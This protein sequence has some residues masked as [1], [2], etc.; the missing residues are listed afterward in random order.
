MNHRLSGVNY[1]DPRPYEIAHRKVAR[2]A[3][4]E[5]MVL[6][7]NEDLFPLSKGTR[8]ALY[9]VGS[10]FPIKGGSGSGDVN[11]RETVN[12]RDGLKNA[13]YAIVNE[14][15]LESYK[16]AYEG[17][18]IAWR[19]EIFT[20]CDEAEK[21]TG[22]PN[23]FYVYAGT[24]FIA[25]VGEDPVKENADVAIFVLS[26]TA[27]EGADRFD[28]EG[29][30]QA[31]KEER[32]FI[33][34]LGKL[35]PA[36]AVILNI[37]SVM[38]LN[39]LDSVENLK[40][41]LLMGQPGMEAGNAVADII[42]G[43]V[44]PGGK[45]TDTWALEYTDYPNSATFSHNNGNVLKEYYEE[46]LYVGY[47]YFD[48]F[49]VPVRYPYGYGLSYTDFAIET[50][51]TTGKC[52]KDATSE[53]SGTAWTDATSGSSGT[54]GTDATSGAAGTTGIR[55]EGA[56]TGEPKVIL[57]VDVKNTGAKYAGTEVVQLYA[58]CPQEK[59]AKE[60]RRMI[61]FAKT[62]TLAPGESQKLEISFP[63]YALASY[64]ESLPGWIL[65]KGTY[66]I[67]AGNSI[68]TSVLAASVEVKEDAV[69][70][71][72]RHICPLKEELHELQ[73][74]ADKLRAK[75]E[76]WLPKTAE[77]PKVTVN[78]GDIITRT[79]VYT[80]AYED[81]P[82]EVRKFVDTLSEEQM[83]LL[84]TGDVAAG[85]GS[86][87]GNAGSRV[88]GSAA[89]TSSC[90][91]EQGLGDFVLADGPAGLRLNKE[92]HVKDG[93]PI[94][95]PFS[96]SIEN[97]FLYRGPELTEGEVMYQFCTAIPVGTNLAQTWNPDTVAA[98]GK[99]VAEEMVE[100]GVVSW[101][102]PGMNIHR[103]PLCGRNF[104]YYSEDPILSGIMAA[105][106]TDG[107][108][109]IHGCGTTIKHFAA[110]NQE[111]NRKGSDS[112][113]SERVLREI[114]LKGFEIAIKLSHPMFIMTSYNFVNG[115]HAAN[116]YD[117]CTMAARD[118]WGF[119]GMIMTDWGTTRN[120]P[121][122]TAAGCLRAGNDI[123]MPGT[124]ED[125][126]NIRKELAEGTLDLKD[127][128]RSV[129]RVVDA[130]WKSEAN[131]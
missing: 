36:V 14:A 88:P 35:Y 3:A 64:D 26:R 4:A 48:T 89:Q 75:R 29:D 100:F 63:V 131:A 16:A 31:T 6:L 61:A 106:M 105:A 52:G 22:N 7:K 50:G 60:Y 96:K 81:T 101:L 10:M 2:E 117:L 34:Q 5:G 109:S 67:F 53:V 86:T 18:R 76:A 90:A 27:G 128:K 104:E 47:R 28:R 80:G 119:N 118:E 43:D 68:D 44:T 20:K 17:A 110:N 115:V 83:I 108:Q 127:L 21:K 32:R 66:G 126:E 9:G 25:P 114:Y 93:A 19:D 8:I 85:Q 129:A 111:D 125:H 94:K 79:A 70:D 56:D 59:L 120:D 51:G 92:Y 12:V 65:E 45:L 23:L 103:N 72:T 40:T 30:Y 13:G 54:A 71:V 107:V 78:T 39:F 15:W 77:L 91:A 11:S 62:R 1:S 74:D 38:D 69:F 116:S 37:G 84:T 121:T 95:E 49:D 113:L 24:P 73:A 42:S 55:Y 112:I 102:A 82:E 57:T 41:I 122:S 124:P 87:I 123:V 33:E 58:Y 99:A 130:V 97:G 98:C 46:G